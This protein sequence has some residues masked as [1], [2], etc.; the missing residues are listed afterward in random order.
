MTIITTDKNSLPLRSLVFL[1]I[2]GFIGKP[3]RY[4]PLDLFCKS[5]K[6]ATEKFQ[7]QPYYTHVIKQKQDNKRRLCSRFYPPLPIK[8]TA[9]TLSVDD[10]NTL[11]GSVYLKRTA[12]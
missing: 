7:D 12:D 2:F 8:T 1:V 6:P 9:A 4:C 5:E 3:P 10:L 11:N